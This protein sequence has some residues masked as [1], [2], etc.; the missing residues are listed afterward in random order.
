VLVDL[1][2]DEKID[3][4]RGIFGILLVQSGRSLSAVQAAVF[5]LQAV[6]VNRVLGA[7]G[8]RFTEPAR[9]YNCGR[10]YAEQY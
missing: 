2:T 4:I 1:L 9:A 3:W 7:N 6:S 10:I 5:L 8:R